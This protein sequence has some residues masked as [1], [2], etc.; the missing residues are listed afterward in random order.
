[1]ARAVTKPFVDSCPADDSEDLQGF[2]RELEETW[3][4]IVEVMEYEFQESSSRRRLCLLSLRSER[5][6]GADLRSRGMGRNRIVARGVEGEPHQA[7]W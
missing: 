7:A 3:N 5:T 4:S 6:A 1:M 2:F